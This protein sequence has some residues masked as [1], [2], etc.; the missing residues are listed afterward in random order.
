[1]GRPTSK[2]AKIAGLLLFVFVLV[3]LPSLVFG[4]LRFP[5]PQ[6]KSGYELPVTTKPESHAGFDQF[7][8][9]T[10]LLVTLSLCSY[11]ALKKRSRRG[12]LL[13]G[14]FSLFYFGFWRKGWLCAFSAIENVALALSGH[15]YAMP[16]T[17]A[18][19]FALPL[20]FAI[21]FGRAFCASVCPHGV[22]QDVVLLRPIKVPSWLE[23][24][25][26]M[27]AY[28]YLGLAVLFAATGSAFIIYQYDPFVIFFRRG[29]SLN[30]L[31]LG[32]SFLLVGMFIGRPYCRYL[33][34]YSVI[35]GWMSKYSKWHLTITPDKCIQCRLC[36]DSCPFGAIR[37]PTQET[38]SRR[39]S[40][41]CWPCCRYL[42]RQAF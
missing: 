19:F 23:H 1:M 30:M 34:P 22:I 26:R 10:V 16:I 38:R 35:L 17:I 3:A 39:G 31:I 12:I 18:V 20:I 13:V 33:C 36:E 6:F 41:F 5:P 24:G 42:S 7:L 11:L 8:D 29:G 40:P 9:I 4:I 2:L 27:F 15:N 37:K 21:L 25:L 28:V 32:V 14:I